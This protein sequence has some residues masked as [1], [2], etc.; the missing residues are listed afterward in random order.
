MI[1]P[2][3]YFLVGEGKDYCSSP[4]GKPVNELMAIQIDTTTINITSILGK[5]ALYLTIISS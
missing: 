5:Y 4:F 1:I 2:I 3:E